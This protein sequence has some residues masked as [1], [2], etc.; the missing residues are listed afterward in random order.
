MQ[1]GSEDV[2][3]DTEIGKAGLRIIEGRSSDSDRFLDAGRG[4][5]A[6]VLIVVSGGDDD[7]NT[8]L[9]KLKIES[10]INK[11]A[12]TFRQLGT[13]CFN[14]HV[15]GVRSIATQTYRS[16][17]GFTGPRRFFSNPVDAGDPVVW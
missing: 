1:A 10:L 8:A 16:N 13:Y 14:S 3:G 6:R 15:Y 9:E 2:D 17:G 11:A 12:V 4:G 7:S 5:V